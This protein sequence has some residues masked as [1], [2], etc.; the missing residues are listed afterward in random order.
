MNKDERKIQEAIQAANISIKQEKG[1]IIGFI[2]PL[3]NMPI[4]QEMYSNMESITTA[5]NM[6][7]SVNEQRDILRELHKIHKEKIG[8]LSDAEYLQAIAIEDAKA[9]LN[10]NDEE[11]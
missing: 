2:G 5:F 1:F 10:C 11:E 9:I 3:G 8:S 4:V 7:E 6:T